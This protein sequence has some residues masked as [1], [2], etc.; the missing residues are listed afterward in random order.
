MK[1]IADRARAN[2]LLMFSNYNRFHMVPPC[3]VSPEDTKQAL[4]I[5][6]DAL[7]AV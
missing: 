1:A 6:D 7:S 3:N 2:G 5:L 4:D